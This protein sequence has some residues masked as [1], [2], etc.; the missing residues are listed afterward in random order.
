MSH[1]LFTYCN[2][3]HPVHCKCL[4]NLDILCK[5]YNDNYFVLINIYLSIYYSIVYK[6][7]KNRK[8]LCYH[9]H[10]DTGRIT[11]TKKSYTPETPAIENNKFLYSKL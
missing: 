6:Y 9:Q 10:T 11:H 3:V 2:Y 7:N 8:K 4:R 1:I 5:S